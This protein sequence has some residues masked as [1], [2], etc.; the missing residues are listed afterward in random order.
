MVGEEI[1][2]GIFSQNIFIAGFSQGG[3][4]AL[5]IAM[6][7][8]YELGGFVSLAGFVP[9]PNVLKSI[10]KRSNKQTPI[11]MVH[12][13]KDMLVPYEKAQKSFQILQ[14]NG[15]LVEPIKVHPKL[16]HEPLHFLTMAVDGLEFLKK[17]FQKRNLPKL[18]F[19]NPENVV[20]VK[21]E[22]V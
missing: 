11:F 9:Y 5:A 21:K 12:G 1:S 3:S 8:Q 19:L 13:Q 10:E 7:S 18:S 22:K 15:Y 14:Q 20:I 16:G 17:I 2:K 6:S 4:L